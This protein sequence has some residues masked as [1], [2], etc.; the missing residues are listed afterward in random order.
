[1]IFE[2]NYTIIQKS[3]IQPC[4][5][6][7]DFL[8]IYN[9]LDDAQKEILNDKHFEGYIDYKFSIVEKLKR[10][11][12]INTVNKIRDIIKKDPYS[13]KCFFDG[14]E[15]DFIV[16]WNDTISYEIENTPGY[17]DRIFLKSFSEIQSYR[18][19]GNGHIVIVIFGDLGFSVICPLENYLVM[20]PEKIHSIM[21][22]FYSRHGFLELKDDDLVQDRISGFFE[23]MKTI[24]DSIDTYKRIYDKYPENLFGDIDNYYVYTHLDEFSRANPSTPIFYVKR[25]L[26]MILREK[27]LT[28]MDPNEM[29]L[30]SREINRMTMEKFSDAWGLELIRQNPNYRLDQYDHII[31]DD[32]SFYGFCIGNHILMDDTGLTRKDYEDAWTMFDEKLEKAKKE[33]YERNRFLMDACSLKF[34]EK[35]PDVIDTD[36]L[37]ESDKSFIRDLLN[38]KIP[39]P[40]RIVNKEKIEYFSNIL[41][42]DILVGLES[43]L[44]YLDDKPTEINQVKFESRVREHP[45]IKKTNNEGIFGYE[46]DRDFYPEYNIKTKKFNKNSAIDLGRA[47]KTGVFAFNIHE[48]AKPFQYV[49]YNDLTKE[50]ILKE[51]YGL[52]FMLV[53]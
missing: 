50:M 43:V 26:E 21:V 15:T 31:F 2:K 7:G 38:G 52:K 47:C 20:Y 9:S 25:V 19:N 33:F 51:K 28:Y 18:G 42:C 16:E 14:H 3:I 29:R 17:G 34:N 12:D 49:F 41:D 46:K 45:W 40:K 4:R 53:D 35:I 11:I 32:G 1:M 6:F 48:L 39:G 36:F 44:A 24:R 37:E 10:G 8:N 30:F 13:L 27:Y 23:I 5:K 22:D